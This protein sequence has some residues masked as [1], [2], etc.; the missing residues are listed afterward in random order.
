LRAADAEAKEYERLTSALKEVLTDFQKRSA[1]TISDQCAKISAELRK[2]VRGL[3]EA[4]CRTVRAAFTQGRRD[5]W[6]CDAA[7]LQ[8]QLE[9]S[10]A[11]TCRE[12]EQEVTK[13]E[14]G[15]FRELKELLTRYNPGWW[16]S[17][18]REAIE[19]GS[20]ELPL[21]ALLGLQFVCLAQ[22]QQDAFSFR[23]P[24]FSTKTLSSLRGRLRP[25]NTATL[26]PPVIHL[27]FASTSML[28]V[29]V[30]NSYAIQMIEVV[31]CQSCRVTSETWPRPRHRRLR[32]AAP[33]RMRRGS[34]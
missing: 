20:L 25:T 23:I 32:T 4:E 1:T 34:S 7:P 6:R 3:S 27:S 21:F 9:E 10:L 33:R 22:I 28:L 29:A 13:L 11:S 17:G 14:S 16:E 30:I 18:S 12:A 19:P 2:V 24:S 15:I 8:R 31:K 26:R 5:V